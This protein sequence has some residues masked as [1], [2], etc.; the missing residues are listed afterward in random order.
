MIRF[1]GRGGRAFTVHVRYV[2]VDLDFS[3]LTMFS[4][5]N[6]PTYL[7]TNLKVPTSSTPPV[8]LLVAFSET[9]PPGP[10]P[11]GTLYGVDRE[12]VEYRA[13]S[14]FFFY[15][16]VPAHPIGNP[17]FVSDAIVMWDVPT[18]STWDVLQ[19]INH[20]RSMS[21]HIISHLT[22]PPSLLASL[23][24]AMTCSIMVCRNIP[25]AEYML[26]SISQSHCSG[27]VE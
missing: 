23:V 7:H 24:G 12:P 14:K 2:P 3:N 21:S 6:I 17:E 26:L 4:A 13:K 22:C 16:S 1:W 10:N 8:Y 20:D 25:S 5:P 9:P 11:S 15:S 27:S 18:Y 19:L